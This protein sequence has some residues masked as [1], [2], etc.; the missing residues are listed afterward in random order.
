MP[1]AGTPVRAATARDDTT[2]AAQL[3]LRAVE[4][5]RVG[6]FSKGAVAVGED[7][8]GFD[9]QVDTDRRVRAGDFHQLVSLFDLE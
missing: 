3:F 5:A 2:G 1:V 7:G 9:T 8:E 4:V 6:L